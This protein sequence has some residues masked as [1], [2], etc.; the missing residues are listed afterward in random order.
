[1]ALRLI[2]P[3]DEHMIPSLLNAE[4]VNSFRPMIRE[5][6]REKS[7]GFEGSEFQAKQIAEML[8]LGLDAPKISK[9]LKISINLL[10][11]YYAH[12]FDTAEALVNAKV[13][14]VALDMA[15]SGR[16]PEMTQFWL[17]TRAGWSEKQRLEITGADG[18][19]LEMVTVRESLMKTILSHE[20]E[21]Q[22]AKGA[23][24][25]LAGPGEEE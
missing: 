7:P 10:Q 17:K 19:P 9:I 13:A 25:A 16:N 8:A 20:V 4:V 12:E 18:G 15:L 5:N 21:V 14:K 2:V 24:L 1:M 3:A 23:R 22:D 11:F 6:E